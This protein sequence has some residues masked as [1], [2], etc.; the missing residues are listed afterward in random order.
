MLPEFRLEQYFSQWEFRAR[1]NLAA[2]DAET[3][4]IAEVLDLGSAE[5]RRRFLDLRLGY[6]ETEGT[7]GLRDAVAAWYGK[8][9][10]ADQVLAFVGAEEGMFCACTPCSSRGVPSVSM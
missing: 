8:G 4:S 2:S 10:A 5:D 7:P 6:I 9:L 1:Y 3:M